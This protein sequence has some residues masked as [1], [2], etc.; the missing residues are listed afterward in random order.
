M[1]L[2][3]IL[4][5]LSSS[6]VG[7]TPFFQYQLFAVHVLPEIVIINLSHR[8]LNRFHRGHAAYILLFINKGCNDQRSCQATTSSVSG[9][10]KILQNHTFKQSLLS[11]ARILIY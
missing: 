6:S 8:G 4:H 5:V 11:F 9:L 10:K 2:I 3:L 7:T 1:Y